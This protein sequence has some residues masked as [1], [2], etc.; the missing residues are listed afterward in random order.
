[1]GTLTAYDNEHGVG[2]ISPA[3]IMQRHRMRR[4]D[5]RQPAIVARLELTREDA[6]LLMRYLI[7]STVE[8]KDSEDGE[9]SSRDAMEPFW[10][11]REKLVFELQEK[12]M[13]IQ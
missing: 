10:K 2:V 8:P 13:E 6:D 1:M 3:T 4:A 11:I 5:D 9:Q 7:T 12:L